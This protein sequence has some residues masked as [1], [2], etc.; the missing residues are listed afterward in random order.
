MSVNALLFFSRIAFLV[1]CPQ[2][3]SRKTA[4]WFRTSFQIMVRHSIIPHKAY[5]SVTKLWVFS[6]NRQVLL[7][8]NSKNTICMRNLTVFVF[9]WGYNTFPHS[10]PHCP[11]A[12]AAC[13]Y[14][15]QNT[16]FIKVHWSDNCYERTTF[17]F[18]DSYR[19]FLGMRKQKKEPKLPA[20]TQRCFAGQQLAV[21]P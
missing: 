3:T 2:T 8:K 5:T 14:I 10:P 4:F 16:L 15:V 12:S 9:L 18:A 6:K 19:L 11:S 1:I 20:S 17:S 7:P 21:S 13:V